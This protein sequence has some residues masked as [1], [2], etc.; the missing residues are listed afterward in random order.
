MNPVTRRRTATWPRH[1]STTCPCTTL[2][3]DS[4]A[5]ALDGNPVVD[6]ATLVLTYDDALDTG[7]EPAVGDFDV[8]VT[9][10]GGSAA[11]R[12][13]SDVAISGSRVVLTLASAVV[14]TDTVTLDYT[15]PATN[16]L[17]DIV[18]NDAA[19]LDDEAV[20]NTTN[21]VPTASNVTVETMVN[22]AHTFAVGN[23][24]FADA[25]AGDALRRVRIVTPPAA[26]TL[27]LRG[28]AVMAN[29]EVAS[30]D[31]EAG[32]LKFTPAMG[33]TGSP[34]AKFTFRVTD[35]E[36]ESALAY[37]MTVNV[38]SARMILPP[39]TRALTTN[40]GQSSDSNIVRRGNSAQA[41]STGSHSAGYALDR[42]EIKSE[43]A[44][45]DS[46]SLSVCTVNASGFPTSTCTALTAPTSFA[47]GTLAFTA[48]ANTVLAADTT[49]TLRISDLN[50]TFVVLDST[51][52]NGEDS[53]GATGWSIANTSDLFS[54]SNV[55]ISNPSGTSFRIAVKGSAIPVDATGAPTIA[56]VA[57][58]GATLRASTAGIV[59]PDGKPDNLAD[60]TYQWVREDA[61]GTNPRDIRGAMS[62]TYLVA[63]ADEGKKLKVEVSFTDNEGN[64]EGPLAS[65]ASDTVVAMAATTVTIA[66][67]RPV[68]INGI[69]HLDFTLTR[70]GNTTAAL[71]VT[72][73]LA[74]TRDFV[75]NSTLNGTH[76]ATFDANATTASFRVA[77]GSFQVSVGEDGEMTASVA[78]GTGYGVGTPS[79]ATV[80]VK[81]AHPAIT[82]WIEQAAYRVREDVAGGKATAHIRAR[83]LAGFPRPS[84]GVVVSLVTEGDEA[85]SPDDYA[86]FSN[87]ANIAPGDWNE[88]GGRF[89]A[90]IAQEVTIVND[91]VVEEDESLNLLLDRTA[92]L[93]A[94]IV[95]LV[96][97]DG[98]D[99]PA[100]G[101]EATLTILND[102]APPMLDTATVN[103]DLAGADLHQGAE[104]RLRSGGGAVHG[105]G[106]HRHGRRA[107][108][109]ERGRQDGDADAGHRGDLRTDGDAQLQGAGHQPG[110]G[111]PP[112]TTPRRSTASPC[113]TWPGTA[114]RRTWRARR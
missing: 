56:G 72:L 49:Y 55:W 90:R 74:Q 109:G 4:T 11:R 1:F 50:D 9:P 32:N 29:Q 102:D 101:C 48:P 103:G 85:V 64:A 2:L 96:Q 67:D 75:P 61:D 46:F 52:S 59:D 53:G 28:M 97:P 82:V 10:S 92:G 79:A 6:G 31:I 84:R 8:Q 91:G 76:T 94:N 34:Y 112:A 111:T 58:V 95:D 110:G 47:A 24:R 18:G 88:V 60:Y 105:G 38:M 42:V 5:P 43:D 83:L 51:S 106:G 107:F 70:G 45:G 89:E 25:D 20:D 15:V 77:V 63:A 37:T 93:P 22:M 62:S 7:S 113:T 13:V 19:A 66:A 30:A 27:A 17:Q 12:D 65:S 23:F 3:A 104:Q 98:S 33:A 99:C 54:N 69:G 80:T 16:P 100:D 86:A 44:E 73:T 81:S 35:G 26:G 40:F 41:F 71:T 87:M 57:Q 36:D 68:I 108:G 114:R 14:S 21:A 39:S 78:S